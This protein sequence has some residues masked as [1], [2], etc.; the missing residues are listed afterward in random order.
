MFLKRNFIF[1]K[2]TEVNDQPH[3]VSFSGC[4]SPECKVRPC[5]RKITGGPYTF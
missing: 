3:V 4:Y 5:T 2:I 1:V